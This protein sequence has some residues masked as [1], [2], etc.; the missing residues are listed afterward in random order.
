MTGT[1]T[2]L[3][4]GA[5]IAG[6][7]LAYWLR[8]HGFR[9][10]VVERAP[11]IRGGGYPIDIRGVAV[12]VVQRMGLLPETRAAHI[13]TRRFTIIG[14]D[15]KPAVSTDTTAIGGSSSD[16]DIELPRGDL[17]AVLYGPTKDDVEYLFDDSIAT[18]DERPDGVDVMFASGGKRTFD[19]VIGADGLHSNVRRLTFGPEERYVRHMG[20][21]SAAFSL[22]NDLGL[23]REILM[24]NTPGRLA[25]LYAV[26]G[27]PEPTALIAFASPAL[28]IDH[29]DVQ[30]QQQLVEDAVDGMGWEVPRLVKAM[31]DAEDFWFDGVSQIRMPGW[32]SGRVALVGDAAFAPSFLS[33]QGTSIALVGAYVLAGELAAAGGDHRVAFPAYERAMRGFVERNQALALTGVETLIPSSRARIWVRNQMIRVA[34]LIAKFGG[35]GGQV[36]KA[37]NSLSL[38]EYQLPL[39]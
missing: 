21:Y 39:R 8:H 22:P 33:G 23:E 15:G 28:S 3:I 19:L 34:P 7:A 18:L 38:R 24:Y 9:P 29:R 32:T 30:R 26:R 25:A 35:L 36:Q 10:T 37:A 20:A 27:R 5:S 6:P 31:R 2:V 12:D 16:R 1:K 13:D 14:S 11:T 4:S 17:T